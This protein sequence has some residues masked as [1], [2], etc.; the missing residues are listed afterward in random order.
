MTSTAP[1]AAPQTA[2]LDL[3][4]GRSVRLDTHLT[5]TPLGLLAVAG[6]VCAILLSVPPIIR[7]AAAASR[8]AEARLRTGNGRC[9][10]GSS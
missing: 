10:V 1:L 3:H 2:H 4:A 5:V 7:A 6:L 9:S 8:S